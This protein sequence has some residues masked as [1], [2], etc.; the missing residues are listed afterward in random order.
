MKKILLPVALVAVAMAS[1]SKDETTSVNNGKELSFSVVVP[2]GPSTRAVTTTANLTNFKVA[3]IGNNAV[4]FN[5]TATKNAS[6]NWLT[7]NTYYWPSYALDFYA[8]SPSTLSTVT[9]NTT[10][11]ALANFTPAA[12]I[13]N[14]EDVIV[15]F[16]SG[17][18]AANETTGVPMLFQHALSQIEVQA[19]NVDHTK[20]KI[21]VIGV[22]IG[23]TPSTSS[24]TF[25]STAGVAG[26]QLA[27]SLWAT[28]TTQASYA[29]VGSTALTL[30][31]THQNIM[32][33]TDNFM[34]IPQQLIPWGSGTNNADAPVQGAAVNGAYISVLCKITQIGS[35]LVLYPDPAKSTDTYAFSAV[36]VGTN[37]LPGNKYTYKL[38]FKPETGGGGLVDPEPTEPSIP[39]VT[40]P[41]IDPGKPV[42][43]SPIFFTVT[44]DTWND[45]ADQ[46]LDM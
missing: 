8:Y 41:E 17:T 33:G 18:K 25:P 3:A 6:N 28:P 42:L 14:Q 11:K 31:A 16:N 37:W 7:A 45:A 36:P 44:V 10:T 5:E 19:A 4:F 35:G 2:K 32:F 29:S 21:E 9:L 38:T 12:D 13:A 20:F 24:F 15:A 22:K 34:L 39:E 1:C 30:N 43:G 40:D 23:Y 46:N 26:T 27:Q